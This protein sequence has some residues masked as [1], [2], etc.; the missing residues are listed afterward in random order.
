MVPETSNAD[1]VTLPGK[2]DDNAVFG[3][4]VCDGLRHDDQDAV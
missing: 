4:G 2:K 3:R 1:T